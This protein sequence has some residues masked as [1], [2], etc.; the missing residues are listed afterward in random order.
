M[1]D[2]LMQIVEEVGTVLEKVDRVSIEK[3]VDL[4]Q[5]D[6]RIFVD[7]EGRSGYVGKC[8]AMRL[9]HLGFEV[10]VM[11]ETNT[12][13]FR[14][15]DVL[16]CISGSG[17]TGSVLLNAEKAQKVGAEIVTV[18]NNEQSSLGMV[19]DHIIKLDATV[20]GDQEN[21]KSIQLLGSLFDQAV[22]LLLDNICLLVSERDRIS[23]EAATQLHV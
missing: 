21:R 11:G 10:Y 12:P 13:S 19:A 22:H 3:T 4:I 15:G 16:F 5:K 17:N 14:D 2:Y 1:S 7:G 23:N 6:G 9:M 8:F 18:T 20:R